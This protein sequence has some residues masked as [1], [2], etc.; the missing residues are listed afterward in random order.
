M[1]QLSSAGNPRRGLPQKLHEALTEKDAHNNPSHA[2]MNVSLRW[3]CVNYGLEAPPKPPPSSND[4]IDAMLEKS[5]F[6]DEAAEEEAP[7]ST[8]RTPTKARTPPEADAE[9]SPVEDAV[10]DGVM[11]IAGFSVVA[12]SSSSSVRAKSAAVVSCAGL[13][14]SCGWALGGTPRRSEPLAGMDAI[15]VD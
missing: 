2:Y 6:F 13:R 4:A 8:H 7:A 1:M 12:R 11:G 3:L 9:R 5:G 14:R 15:D 10:A